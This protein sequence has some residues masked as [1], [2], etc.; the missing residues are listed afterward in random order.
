MSVDVST[1]APLL[2]RKQCHHG[3]PPTNLLIR[4]RT[5]AAIILGL[6]PPGDADD[7]GVETA[8]RVGV[9]DTFRI[10]DTCTHNLTLVHRRRSPSESM[11]YHGF[12]H[13]NQNALSIRLVL[14][15][16]SPP[17]DVDSFV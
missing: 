10:A 6:L 11:P 9:I 4:R 17:P 1:A 16:P 3:T 15:G 2:T 14:V 13:Q 7:R 12:D 5:L 8:V